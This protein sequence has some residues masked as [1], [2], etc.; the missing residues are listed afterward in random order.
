MARHK[1]QQ[2]SYTTKHLNTV[3]KESGLS[4]V[5]CKHKDTGKP[6]AYGLCRS[7]YDEVSPPSFLI[8]FH[9]CH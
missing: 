1:E 8:T 5:L 3:S 6:F 7:C 9:I 4:E 2:G